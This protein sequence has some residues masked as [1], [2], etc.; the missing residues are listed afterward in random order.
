VSADRDVEKGF[1]MMF[2]YGD[3]MTGWG[4][5]VVALIVVLVWWIVGLGAYALVRFI[6][7]ADRDPRPGATPEE[8]LADRFARGEIDAREFHERL[9]VLD[10]RAVGRP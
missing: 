1:V 10:G 5:P 6:S 4:P 2:W 7:R 8:V 3:G 9:E